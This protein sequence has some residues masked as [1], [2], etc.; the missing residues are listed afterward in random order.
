M[1]FNI[2]G[3]V[4][5]KCTIV[6]QFDMRDLSVRIR[7]SIA[8]SLK[9]GVIV[10]DGL[11]GRI[12]SSILKSSH[13]PYVQTGRYGRFVWENLHTEAHFKV[14]TDILAI[15]EL[16]LE[17]KSE[18]ARARANAMTQAAERKLPSWSGY[19]YSI[20]KDAT[21]TAKPDLKLES[22][23]LDRYIETLTSGTGVISISIKNAKNGGF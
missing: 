2:S 18:G 5:S 3:E 7:N 13:S 9:T 11:A 15:A 14:L 6:L 12:A 22:N 1:S 20:V 21:V 23:E 4:S 19:H 17:N 16:Y 8:K 10:G